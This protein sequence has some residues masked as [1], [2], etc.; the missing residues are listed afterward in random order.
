M[1][2]LD[3]LTDQLVHL[4]LRVDAAM[5]TDP[6]LREA[7][8][9]WMARRQGKIMPAHADMTDLPAILLPH[10]FYAHL[11]INGDQHWIVSEAGSLAKLVLG[12]TGH[13]PDEVPDRRMAVRLRRLFELVARKAEP[14]SVMFEAPAAEGYRQLVEIYAAP[15]ATPEALEHQMFAVINTR[16]E[17]KIDTGTQ[18]EAS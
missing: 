13:E 16:L 5:P 6:V 2:E 1:T 11:A 17:A 9:F 12:I 7:A 3:P 14:Y 10:V 15:L 18:P 8:E 4:F